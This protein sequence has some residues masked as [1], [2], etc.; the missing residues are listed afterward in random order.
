MPD[1][2]LT[3]TADVAVTGGKKAGRMSERP[4]DVT[5][6]HISRAD[7]KTE[8]GNDEGCA[9]EESHH[10]EPTRSGEHRCPNVELIDSVPNMQR[11]LR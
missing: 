2:P 4:E 6:A 9:Q 3:R 1:D 5:D 7:L 8:D 11:F 10:T